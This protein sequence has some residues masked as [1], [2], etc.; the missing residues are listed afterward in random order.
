MFFVEAG[1]SY[2]SSS[3]SLLADSLDFFG[4]AANYGISLF[5]VGM[6]ISARAYASLFK[7]VTM[8]LFGCFIL[9]T[10]A[11]R[12]FFGGVPDP[13]T[14]GG[15][16][17][18]ALVVNVS[19]AAL[20]Y[21]YRNGDSNMVSIW[22]CSRNDAIGNVLV[23]I[24]AFGVASTATRWPDLLVAGSVALLSLSAAIQIIRLALTELSQSKDAKIPAHEGMGE[25]S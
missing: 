4:D 21:K 11:Y 6:A 25:L 24:A 10:A 3:M 8:G 9:G 15:V 1:A 2:F 19:V 16:A 12:V 14:M 5:V 17:I 22:L 18:L 23:L 20:L 7:G 13:V